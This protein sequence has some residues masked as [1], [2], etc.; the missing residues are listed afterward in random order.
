MKLMP[1]LV[2]MIK[3]LHQK[4]FLFRIIMLA[5]INYLIQDLL[6]MIAKPVL[7]IKRQMK[8]Y[9]HR[10]LTYFMPT[11]ELNF[12]CYYPLFV[13]DLMKL[14]FT[15]VQRIVQPLLIITVKPAVMTL[16]MG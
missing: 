2:L 11:V 5:T 15:F 4:G 9:F 14:N 8:D 10:M 12:N 6:L 3:H 13:H 1:K 16:M 7:A